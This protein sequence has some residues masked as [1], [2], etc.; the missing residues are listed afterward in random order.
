[1]VL[2]SSN[3]F[4]EMRAHLIRCVGTA[5][6]FAVRP[7]LKVPEVK[8]GYEGALDQTVAW[9]KKTLG[10]FKVGNYLPLK[11]LLIPHLLKFYCQIG[12]K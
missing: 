12:N 3:F 2:F 7:N 5:H 4:F 1:M 8:A 6:G 9:F 11:Y 10:S